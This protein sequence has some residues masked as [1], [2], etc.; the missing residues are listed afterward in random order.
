MNFLPMPLKNLVLHVLW[1]WSRRQ[2][3]NLGYETADNLRFRL[4]IPFVDILSDEELRQLNE[5]LPWACFVLDSH[6][7][8][9][10]DAWS[11]DK[12]SVPQA[13]PDR[14]IIDLNRRFPLK[15]RVVVEIG[16]F[17]GIHTVALS[18]LAKKVIAVDSRIENVVKTTIRCAMFGLAPVVFHCDVEKSWPPDLDFHCDVLHHVGVLYHLNDPITHLRRIA[19]LVGDVIM[20]D[21]HVAEKSDTLE[22]LSV[23][24]DVFRVRRYREGGRH[25]PFSGMGRY[26]HWLLEENL[27]ELL[28][29]LGFGVIDVAERRQERNGKRILLY[30]KR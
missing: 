29:D 18:Q 28:G 6:G 20:L 9:F 10:G 12:R 8:K 19:P 4:E 23:D 5:M 21:T 17:E 22:N 16:C 2:R 15:D 24:G 7:R 27:I 30:A 14:R 13:I 1:K 26:S 11:S 25:D 3:H